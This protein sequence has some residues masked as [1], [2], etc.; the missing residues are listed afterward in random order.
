MPKIDFENIIFHWPRWIWHMLFWLIFVTFFAIVYGSFN[1][2]YG[3]Q[4]Q[5]QLTDAIVQVPAVYLTLYW[6]MPN[7]LFKEQ[8]AKFFLYLVLLILAFSTLAW[9]DSL[10]IQKPLFWPEEV[11]DV[12]IFNV[13]KI[14]KYTTK[15]YPVVVLA[16][17]IKWF[18]YG[19]I[20]QKNTVQLAEEKLQAE[21]KFLKAQVHPHFL[22]NTL[23]NL[24]ALT[25]KQS[26][27]APDMVLKLS[28]LLNYML[29]ECNVE[30][31]ALKKELKLVKD[32]IDLEKIRY[33]ER[34]N[35]S[36]DIK[37]ENNDIR[38][39]PLIILPFVENAFKHGVSDILEESWVSIDLEL[40]ASHI[41]LKVENSKSNMEDGEDRFAY[42]EG[43]GLTNVKRRLELLYATQH[44]FE[45]HESD[46]SYLV[47][48]KLFF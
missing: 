22:F 39:A 35:V 10:L 21:L 47:V 45:I 6:L 9:F 28:E 3:L 1:E 24:Y 34:L 8:Y 31:V 15:I 42:K 17:V 2:E 14:L 7:Y 44:Q 40:K 33:G 5:I 4:F 27:D 36:V 18:K 19:Y 20:Q 30:R 25:L 48:L 12:S 37:G 46:T 38:I 23:N 43:I 29:Y 16:V 13:G 11:W 32:Y 26:K 41:T